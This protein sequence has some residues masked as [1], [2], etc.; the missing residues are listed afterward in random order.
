MI[1]HS[2]IK[3]RNNGD[4]NLQE[5]EVSTRFGGSRYS[6]PVD[7]SP[8]R[9]STYNRQKMKKLNNDNTHNLRNQTKF[10][11]AI[12]ILRN[13]IFKSGLS[14]LLELKNQFQIY[15]KDASVLES[16]GAFMKSPNYR[17]LKSGTYTPK[18]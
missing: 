13:N 18:K 1:E 11:N 4:P 9:Y 10:T 7:K 3:E 14:F 17:K 6:R 5:K 2:K 15:E 12:K 8:S 16:R